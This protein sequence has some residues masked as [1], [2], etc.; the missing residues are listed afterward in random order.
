MESVAYHM[1]MIA[2]QVSPKFEITPFTD[3]GDL[4]VLADKHFQKA[5]DHPEIYFRDIKGI[6]K[7]T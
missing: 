7:S 2:K 5:I 6:I 3:F 1:H 4:R